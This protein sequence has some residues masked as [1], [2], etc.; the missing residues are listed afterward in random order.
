MSLGRSSAKKMRV[1]STQSHSGVGTLA[2]PASALSETP[3]PHTSNGSCTFNSISAVSSYPQTPLFAPSPGLINS[4]TMSAVSTTG[5]RSPLSQSTQFHFHMPSPCSVPLPPSAIDLASVPTTCA[6]GSVASYPMGGAFFGGPLSGNGSD[7]ASANGIEGATFFSADTAAI[8]TT[9]SDSSMYNVRRS[10]MPSRISWHGPDSMTQEFASAHHHQ[11]PAK[12]DMSMGLEASD[13]GLSMFAEGRS[14]GVNVGANNNSNN[15][16][17]SSADWSMLAGIP[18]PTHAHMHDETTAA[19]EFSMNA[20]LQNMGGMSVGVAQVSNHGSTDGYQN[21]THHQHHSYHHHQ[22]Q[23]SRPV[24]LMA[25]DVMVPAS[26]DNCNSSGNGNGN[27]GIMSF[28]DEMIRD[29]ASLMNVFGQD[30][31]GWQC[32]T[33][34]NTIDPAALCAVDPEANPL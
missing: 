26:A 9:G 12:I 21:Q 20:P 2:I 28:Y 31:S 14:H 24:G 10:N 13:L 27:S 8:M 3:M 32:P 15:V 23:H 11:H 30:L 33:K 18:A 4:S 17:A 6:D 1:S 29:S 7:A 34:T 16:S 22:Q 25:V 5:T 19:T